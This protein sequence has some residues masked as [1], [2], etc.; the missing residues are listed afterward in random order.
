[1]IVEFAANESELHEIVGGPFEKVVVNIVPLPR[2]VQFG[3]RP[4]P[5]PEPHDPSVKQIFPLVPLTAFP[6]AVA[7]P[8][9]NPEMPELTGSPVILVATPLTGV[10][11]AGAIRVGALF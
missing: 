2:E 8:V 6:S 10:P 1:M 11:S 3:G 7:T 4:P 9:P 5:L